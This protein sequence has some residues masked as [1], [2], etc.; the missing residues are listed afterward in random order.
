[1]RGE[2]T[3]VRLQQE[4]NKLQDVNCIVWNK[5]YMVLGR[6]TVDSKLVALQ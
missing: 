5:V 3:E 1:M 6:M 2:G 4:V